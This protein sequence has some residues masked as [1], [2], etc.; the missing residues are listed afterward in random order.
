[1]SRLVSAEATISAL[2]L[3]VGE[4]N[5]SE[6]LARVRESY[7]TALAQAEQKHRLQL[8]QAMAETHGAKEEVEAKVSCC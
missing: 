5:S 1:M 6:C 2:K 8:A 7:S 4:L 3:Q